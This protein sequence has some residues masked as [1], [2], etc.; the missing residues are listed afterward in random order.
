M[1]KETISR[2]FV[3]AFALCVVCSVLVSSAA[4]Y[5]R[6][7]QTV[8][9]SLDKKRNILTAAGLEAGTKTID[10]LFEAIETKVVDLE[11]GA[12]VKGID[13]E[14]YD[15]RRAAKDP[16]SS[17]LV[18]TDEDVGDIKRRAK[19]ASVYLVRKGDE[20][21][22]IILPIHG[23]GLWSTLYGFVTLDARDLST[24]RALV[25]Y[26]HAETPGLGGEVDNPAWKALWNGKQAFDE[27]GN[28]RIT[29]I[30]GKADP[31]RAESV[32]Q[33]D[34]LSG[35]T[36]TARG[37]SNMLTYWLGDSGFGPYIQ[38]LKAQTNG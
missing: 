11:S 16:S 3:V 2:T 19:H 25:Y 20:V 21:R 18:P 28:V 13:P 14:S 8:N 7:I 24:I 33:V 5:L 34:G 10:E 4:V 22:K 9:K 32:Y 30:K 29:V 35:A 38:Q 12:Y 36:I 31:S 17:V 6:P 37:V 26:E 1:A 23:L 27:S 15:Q